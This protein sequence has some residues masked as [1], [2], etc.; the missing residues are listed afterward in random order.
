MRESAGALRVQRLSRRRKS[1]LLCRSLRVDSAGAIA[2]RNGPEAGLR[3]IDAVLQDGEL[4]NYCLAHSA[5]VD[6][7]RR[8]G[9]TDEAQASYEKALTLTQQEPEG[10]FLESDSAVEIKTPI[11]ALECA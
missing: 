8:L 2:K 5:R 1:K 10:Q 3:H 4:A 11:R 7:Y 6:M 9:R